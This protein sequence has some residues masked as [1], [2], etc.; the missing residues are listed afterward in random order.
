MP[1]PIS[2]KR[3]CLPA[4]AIGA[5]LLVAFAFYIDW[6]TRT[7]EGIA[8]EQRSV[9]REAQELQEHA[10][11]REREVVQARAE[12]EQAGLGQAYSILNDDGLMR[13]WQAADH[14]NKTEVVYRLTEQMIMRGNVPRSRASS[15]ELYACLNEAYTPA[16][17]T[18]PVREIASACAVTMGWIR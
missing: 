2:K 9:E 18:T 3:G 15:A 4:I 13:D 11:Q 16:V 6:W 7:P 12:A 5:L 14:L 10:Q 1:K 8:A 17:A